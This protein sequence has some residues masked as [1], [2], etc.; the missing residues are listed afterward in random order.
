MGEPAMTTADEGLLH[1]LDGLVGQACTQVVNSVGSVLLV[2]IGPL[3]RGPHQL[4][5]S[6]PQG[7]RALMVDS[8]WRIQTATGVLCD[9]NADD[10]PGGALAACVAGLVGRVVTS[11]DVV[12][13]AW[14]LQLSFSGDVRL[15]VFSD[16]AAD[17]PYA[18]TILGTDG[19]EIVAGPHLE[20]RVQW[21][22]TPEERST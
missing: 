6:P 17:R 13:P 7:W 19:L 14:D 10:A 3:G 16:S 18:W 11:V 21:K 8:P 22:G 1:V 12:P 4:D 2:D 15:V 5:R 20:P 9:W